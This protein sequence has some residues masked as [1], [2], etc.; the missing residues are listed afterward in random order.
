MAITDKLAAIGDAI[1][2]KTGKPEKL[3]LDQMPDEI[4]GISGG[5]GV[6]VPTYTGEVEVE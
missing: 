4:A 2:A 1:R 3:T 6:V 5:G